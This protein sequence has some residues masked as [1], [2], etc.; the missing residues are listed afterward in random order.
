M[1]SKKYIC[2]YC[3]ELNL[4]L[5]MTNYCPPPAVMAAFALIKKATIIP[6]RPIAVP[7]ISTIKTCYKITSDR[8]RIKIIGMTL[9]NRFW[10]AASDKAAPLPT[11]P[12]H[13]PQAKLDNPVVKP[14][15][16]I[17]NPTKV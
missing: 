16:N 5:V 3:N 11:I 12:T 7:K 8:N 4:V 14:A 6:N 15:P 10:L 1:R 13:N 9:T 2:N 17:L